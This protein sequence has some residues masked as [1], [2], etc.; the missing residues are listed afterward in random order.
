[1]IQFIQKLRHAASPCSYT[2][3]P[4]SATATAAAAAADDDDDG[5]CDQ[6]AQ[7]RDDLSQTSFV[8]DDLQ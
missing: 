6:L 7:A 2:P 3:L 8:N 1:L 4:Q 5:N